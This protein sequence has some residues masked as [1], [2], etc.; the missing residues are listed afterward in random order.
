MIA[1]INGILTYNIAPRII[2]EVQGGIG[3][4]IDVPMSTAYKLP[5]IGQNIR[6]HTHLIIK[7]DAH[8]LYGFYTIQEKYM[9]KEFIRISGVGARTSLAILS[10]LSIDDII[11]TVQSNRVSLLA[12]IP[13]IGKKTA[14]RLLLELSNRLSI[15]QTYA[16]DLENV[17]NLSNSLSD[18]LIINT[19]LLNIN[20]AYQNTLIQDTL[21]ALI[22]LGY[23]EKEAYKTV[24]IIQKN[25]S[26]D[27][28]QSNK[29]FNLNDYIKKALFILSGQEKM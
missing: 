11:Q 29:V 17:S 1:N 3:Y 10:G 6:L 26:K 8:A 5:D 13:G 25:E 23:S 19:D 14:E 9:F 21:N 16:Y 12:T 24:K 7:E 28:N 2:I 18:N 22:A 4:E 15:L 20:S 27:V